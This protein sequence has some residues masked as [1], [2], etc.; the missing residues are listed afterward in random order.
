MPRAEALER[1]VAL[2]KLLARQILKLE[3]GGSGAALQLLCSPQGFKVDER[4]LQ[5]RVG[6]S[7]LLS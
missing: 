1:V 2:R 7:G 6:R 4:T 5:V 3:G